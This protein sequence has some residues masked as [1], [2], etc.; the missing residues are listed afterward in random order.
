MFER[1]LQ[2]LAKATNPFEGFLKELWTVWALDAGRAV[3]MARWS[4]QNLPEAIVHQA[5]AVQQQAQAAQ[6]SAQI[7]Q[8]VNVAL[9]SMGIFPG[10][11][12]GT[13]FGLGMNPDHAMF[14]MF[15]GMIR[16]NQ[17]DPPTSPGMAQLAEAVL[18]GQ[19][20]PIQALIATAPPVAQQQLGAA[21]QMMAMMGMD[22]LLRLQAVIQAAFALPRERIPVLMP[23]VE[24]A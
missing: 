12:G 10:S 6:A 11:G 2:G 19:M 5:A 22:Q 17:G 1:L 21:A 7:D 20:D 8:Q 24:R 9:G 16:A 13:S 18:R 14:I 15:M 3:L 23:E 4:W